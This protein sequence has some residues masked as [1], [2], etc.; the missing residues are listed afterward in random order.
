M[1]L[2]EAAAAR[3]R[4]L[5][6]E[7]SE[8]VAGLR[9][10]VRKGGCAGLEYDMSFVATPDPRDEVIEDRGVKLFLAPA[11]IL[12]LLGAEVDY[13]ETTL[14]SGFVFNNPNQTGSC[15]CGA[16]VSLSPAPQAELDRVR[17]A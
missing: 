9:L 12:Y 11:A 5:L 17:G 2:T 15:G 3:I 13:N 4:D 14:Q 16:S 8:P 10:G 7:C 1:T 6:A